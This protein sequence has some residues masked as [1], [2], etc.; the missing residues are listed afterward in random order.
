MPIAN[1]NGTHRDR[2]LPDETVKDIKMMLLFSHMSISSI[3][4]YKGVS[5]S[6]VSR[7]K[8][9]DAYSHVDID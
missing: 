1:F 3:A 2:D 9:G 7:I 5:Q 6:R 4:R 8:L